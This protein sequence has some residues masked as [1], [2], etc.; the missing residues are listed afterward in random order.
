MKKL[1]VVLIIV[2]SA[3]ILAAAGIFFFLMP[4]DKIVAAYDDNTLK[5]VVEGELVNS[6]DLPRISDNQILLPLDAVEKYLDP[7]IYWDSK[8]KKVTVTTKDKVIRMKTDSLNAL[9]NNKPVTLNIPVVEDKGT[10]FIP[11]EFLSD[12]YNIEIAYLK[13]KNIIIIDNKNSLRQL[14]EPLDQRAAVRKDHSIHAPIIKTFNL[15]TDKSEDRTLRI[16]EEYDRWYKVRTSDGAI[17]YIEKKYVVVRRMMV[18][19]VPQEESKNTAWKPEKGKIN[20]VWEFAYGKSPDTAKINKMDGLDVLSPTWFHVTDEKGTVKNEADIKYVDWAHKNGYKIW[21]HLNNEVNPTITGKVLNNTDVRDGIIRQMLSYASLYKLDGINIDF[22]NINK[23]DKDALTQFVR[24]ATPLFKEQG[25]VVSIDVGIPDGSANWSLCYDHKALGKVVDFVALMTYDQT[26]SS[27]SQAGS[28]AQLPWVEKK[29][30]RTLE[31]VPREKLLL[32]L[33]FYTRLWKEET[34]KDG[35]TIVSSP[36]ALSMEDAK[37]LIKDNNAQTKWDE[38]SGQFYTEYKKD[39]ASYKIWIEDENSINL[40]SALVQ[41]YNLAGAASW[42]RGFESPEIW[43]VLAR[44]LKTTGNYQ[45]WLAIN[46]D[47]RYVFN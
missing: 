19:S 44:N 13:E 4:N 17:G 18:K 3:A 7:N 29:L 43:S 30:S 2:F 16:F 23:Q 12:F 32:G 34:G 28:V 46:K 40:K 41:K 31:M 47:K 35:K 22:E 42:R 26:G 33:P 15:N 21:A 10:V 11:I 6:K 37:K 5:L 8:L 36:K 20:L 9:I 39:N 25:L 27:S 38:A 24:E 45:E 1:V 14:A